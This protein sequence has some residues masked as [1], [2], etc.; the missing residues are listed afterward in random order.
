MKATRVEF[1]DAVLEKVNDVVEVARPCALVQGARLLGEELVERVRQNRDVRELVI[2]GIAV[3]GPP[4]RR[5][6]ENCLVSGDVDQRA[7]KRRNGEW[8]AVC[9]PPLERR[10]AL[11]VLAEPHFDDF[12]R[13]IDAAQFARGPGH[14]LQRGTDLVR[15]VRRLRQQ[16]EVEILGK[17][18]GL[19]V[20]LLDARAAFEDPG[21]ARRGRQSEPGEE[22][23]EDVVL[24][25]DV[26]AQV[27][28]RRAIEDV[29]ALNHAG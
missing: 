2:V 21:L 3:K 7:G 22:P 10:F 13:E 29:L 11:L 24:L 12:A 28:L 16:G 6:I 18:I 19:D 5:R 9:D 14:L 25:H 15:R 23:A 8:P 17:A 1:V 27:P 4:W 20:A 26:R